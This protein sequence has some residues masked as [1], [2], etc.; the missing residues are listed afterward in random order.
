MLLVPIKR[1]WWQRSYRRFYA[2]PASN[3]PYKLNAG[4]EQGFDLLVADLK[5]IINPQPHDVVLDV[6]GGNGELSSKVFSVCKRVIVT[7]LCRPTAGIV[8]EFVNADMMH[9]PF[10]KES[11]TIVF[12]YSVFPHLGS[13]RCAAS[14]LRQWAELLRKGGTLFVGDIPERKRLAVTIA[15]GFRKPTLTLA[16]KYW[17]AVATLTYFSRRRLQGIIESLGLKGQTLDQ[18]ASRRFSRERFDMLGTKEH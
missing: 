10:L 1:W 16:G 2:N 6:G 13:Q 17:F 7:D 4:S 11:F 14:I 12:A 8:R 15:R 9:Q 5:N 18:P 3:S